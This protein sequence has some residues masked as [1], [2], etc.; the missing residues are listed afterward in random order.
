[1]W[2]VTPETRRKIRNVRTDGKRDYSQWRREFLALEVTTS[3]TYRT[4]STN[5]CNLIITIA[6]PAVNTYTS[7]QYVRGA[8]VS[9]YN[10]DKTIDEIPKGANY[11]QPS[12]RWWVAATDGIR[13]SDISVG[14]Q[15]SIPYRYGGK[16]D[17]YKKK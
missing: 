14:R 5:R 11:K 8:K 17:T 16:K 9:A 3:H 10:V 15:T 13:V 1:M 2:S 6:I 4:S 12:C 7:C